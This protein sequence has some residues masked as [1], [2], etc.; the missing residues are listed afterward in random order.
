MN[1]HFRSS[2]HLFLVQNDFSPSCFIAIGLNFHH[3]ALTNRKP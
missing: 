1:D 2:L 3:V